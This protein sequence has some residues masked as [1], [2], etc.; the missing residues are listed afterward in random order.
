MILFIYDYEYR[1]GI[2]IR[3]TVFVYSSIS[4]AL[5]GRELIAFSGN[6]IPG[7]L[8]HLEGEIVK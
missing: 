4:K 2:E 7:L 6:D 8:I 3:Y 1:D 5:K